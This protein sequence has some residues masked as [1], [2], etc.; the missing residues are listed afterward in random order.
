MFLRIYTK[1]LNLKNLQNFYVSI[2]NLKLNKIQLARDPKKC[3]KYH[4][5]LKSN[6][7]EKV[8]IEISNI[9]KINFLEKILLSAIFHTKLFKPILI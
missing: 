7:K 9:H 4:K 1:D 8:L 3:L 2:K 6:I 5:N